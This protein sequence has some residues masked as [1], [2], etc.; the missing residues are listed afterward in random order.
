MELKLGLWM[1]LPGQSKVSVPY[2]VLPLYFDT[3]RTN[4]GFR[5]HSKSRM[6]ITKY[7]CL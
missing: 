6:N 1:E 7:I 4:D 5:C 2:N 3:A